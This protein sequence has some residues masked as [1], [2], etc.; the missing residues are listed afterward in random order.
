LPGAAA[1]AVVGAAAGLVGSAAFWPGA[2]CPA[3]GPQAAMA[4]SA[5]LAPVQA[6]NRR[7][8][9]WD[10]LILSLL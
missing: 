1:G 4:A 10:V 2:G 8:L 5:A 7:R 3:L 6:R 9:T